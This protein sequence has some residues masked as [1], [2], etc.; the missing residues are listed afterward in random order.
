MK[1]WNV[2]HVKQ[3][4]PRFVY[5]ILSF[6]SEKQFNFCFLF[7]SI[8]FVMT[9]ADDQFIHFRRVKLCSAKIA[10]SLEGR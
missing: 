4:F 1:N 6:L 3:F 9:V 8:V 2:S 5:K 7:Y 10:A